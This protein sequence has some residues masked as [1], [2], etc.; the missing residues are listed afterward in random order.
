MPFAL[1]LALAPVAGA[2]LLT[3]LYDGEALFPSR[4][5]AGVCMGF[6]ALGL[7]GFVLASWLGMTP[8]ALALAGAAGASPLLLLL[9]RDLR[10]LA[11]Q[12]IAGSARAVRRAFALRGGAGALVFYAAAALLFWFVFAHAM[13]QDARG[14]FTGVDTNIGDLPFHIAVVAGFAYGDNFPPQHPEFADV[15][16]TYPFVVDFVTAMFVRAGASLQGAMFWQNFVMMMSLVGLLHRWAA[17]LTRD[18]VAA[19]LSVALVILSGG[20][21]WWAFLG[22]AGSSGRGVFGLLGGLEHD[23]TVMGHLGYQWGNAVTAL[24]VTQRGILLGVALAA[25][26]L[27]LWWQA[28]GKDVGDGGTGGRG[29]RGK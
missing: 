9:R 29:D 20:F 3:Y 25:A 16:L 10:A 13:Y 4:L 1:L 5:C 8:A 18:R 11:G 22:E 7:A 12:D 26:V 19:L 6:A 14:I 2:T 24:F 28:A 23:Y 21:G 15:R 17:K 27:T